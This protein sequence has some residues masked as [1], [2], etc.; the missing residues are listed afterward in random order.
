MSGAKRRASTADC[1]APG[2]DRRALGVDCQIAD[3]RALATGQ[4]DAG[5]Q[6]M[7]VTPTVR[8]QYSSRRRREAGAD[9]I[10]GEDDFQCPREFPASNVVVV[11]VD[12][13]IHERSVAGRQR[14][15]LLR[16]RRLSLHA[17]VVPAVAQLG[18]HCLRV[19]VAPHPLLEQLGRALVAAT[20]GV[21]ARRRALAAPAGVGGGG[22]GQTAEAVQEV[23]P[24]R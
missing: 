19:G 7:S 11:D 13:Q 22:D 12:V 14:T 24:R 18:Q 10:I 9:P 17:V 16:Q 5:S 6:P 15:L 8:Y 1:R 20:V 3:C 2:T 23:A 21:I 4:S